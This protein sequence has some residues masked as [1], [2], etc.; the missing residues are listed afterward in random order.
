MVRTQDARAR[1]VANDVFHGSL[2][3]AQQGYVR[4]Q[5]RK[6]ILAPPHRVGQEDEPLAAT[7]MGRQEVVQV[8]VHRH[9]IA[10]AAA[11]HNAPGCS[12]CRGGRLD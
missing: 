6:K 2:V 1:R 10:A 7:V 8:P 5:P 11:H 12:M 4:P 3:A 9:Q